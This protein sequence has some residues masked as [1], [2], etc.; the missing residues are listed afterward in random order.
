[1][2]VLLLETLATGLSAACVT[3]LVA[4]R[5]AVRNAQIDNITKE[6]TKWRERL[7][8]LADELARAVD[9]LDRSRIRRSAQ[10]LKLLL[11][12]FELEDQQI[13]SAVMRLASCSVDERHG[14]LDEVTT[15]LSLLLKH[16][17]ECCKYET[18]LW[19]PRWAAPSGFV[20]P[21]DRRRQYRLPAIRNDPRGFQFSSG[22]RCSS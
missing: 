14:F 19:A 8:E 17:W 13:V 20:S 12:P 4:L 16:D 5:I 21:L 15:R 18:R 9:T 2:N 6:R 22:V 11:N 1:M 10:E 3:A 7:R